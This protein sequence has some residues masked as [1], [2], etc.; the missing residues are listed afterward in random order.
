MGERPVAPTAPELVLE[1]ET[2]FTVMRPSRDGHVG[3]APL[4]EVVIDGAD[5]SS[6]HAVPRPE[7]GRW[8][9]EGENCTSSHRRRTTR[10][11]GTDPWSCGGRRR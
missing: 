4:S 9:P 5:V 8:T 3:R 7:A 6:H 1:T 10:C 2:G 11:G